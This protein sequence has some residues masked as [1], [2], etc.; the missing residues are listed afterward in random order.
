METGIHELTAAYALDALDVDDRASY[1]AHLS[2]CDRCRDE[3]AAFWETT[4]ALAVAT[5]GPAPRE[6]LRARI[7]EAARA[8]RQTVVPFE[9]RNRRLVPAL[10]AVAA[11]AAAAAIGI[12]LY[13][14][15]VSN[16]LDDAQSALV[17]HRA[18]AGGACR[19]GLARRRAGRGR[20]HGSWSAANGDA[21]LV[22]D[23]VEP[24][25]SGKTY[26]AWIIEGD[27]RPPGRACSPAADG[28]DVVLIDGT[29]A[30]GAVVAV[31]VES[32]GGVD[33]PTTQP[34]VASEPRLRAVAERCERLTI[35]HRVVP[36]PT[37]H[38]F[39]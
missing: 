30:P 31:T 25:P 6:E 20:R 34:I 12:G 22:L 26:E 29:V 21:V 11:I 23:T 15:N 8:E 7:L 9:P 16:D 13:A 32:A 3:L 5:A 24:A 4:E 37:V 38:S 1:E 36:I 35:G 33:A 28:Q 14:V 17:D 10:G 27:A 19:S 2:G 18:G 39:G